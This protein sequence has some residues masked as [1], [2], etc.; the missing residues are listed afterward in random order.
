MSAI[1]VKNLTY[2]HKPGISPSL[3]DIDLD[4][5]PGSRTILIGANG[6]GKSTLLQILAGKR[7][8][9]A[10]GADIRVQGKDVFREYLHGVTFLGTEWA[11]NPVVRGDIVVASFLDSVGGWRYKERR[12]ELLDILDVDLDWH[13]HQISD[14]ERRRVQLVMGLMQPWD[15]L[16]LDEVTVDLDVLVRD[17]LLSFLQADSEKRNATIIYATHIYDGLNNFPTHIAHMRFGKMVTPPTSWPPSA[18]DAHAVD[19]TSKLGPNP[20]LYHT[21]LQWLKEDR[22]HRRELEAQGRKT[23]GARRNETV[24]SD[25]E[26]FYRKYDY[27]H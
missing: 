15:V 18:S 8:V 17:D 25:S 5:P 4:L 22:E 26:T 23:R 24:P 3:T 10:P 1:S 6:A 14:G 20:L 7:L 13:M 12:D 19:I 2:S 9:S 11:M 27:S 16:L 21:A